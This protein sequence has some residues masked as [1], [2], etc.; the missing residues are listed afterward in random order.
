MGMSEGGVKFD[1]T[2][3]IMVV[4]RGVLSRENK[5]LASWPQVMILNEGITYWSFL[6]SLLGAGSV[7]VYIDSP[8]LRGNYFGL[9]NTEINHYESMFGAMKDVSNGL[10]DSGLCLLQGTCIFWYHTPLVW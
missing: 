8:I 7:G 4:E 1:S 6:V 5:V 9:K 10:W 2:Q 3:K